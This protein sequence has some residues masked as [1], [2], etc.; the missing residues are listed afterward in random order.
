MAMINSLDAI[1]ML[2]RTAEAADIQGRENQLMEHAALQPGSQFQ[3]KVKRNQRQA[4]ETQNSEKMNKDGGSGKGDRHGPAG[5]ALPA[6]RRN[7]SGSFYAAHSLGA[8]LEHG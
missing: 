3:E 8:A 2:P 4:V 6:R 7:D 1:T 5:F